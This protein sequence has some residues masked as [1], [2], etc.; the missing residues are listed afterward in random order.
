M[1]FLVLA[2]LWTAWCTLHSLLVSARFIGF[3]K[4]RLGDRYRFTRILF[5]IFAVLSL[6]PVLGYS[7]ALSGD[8]IIHWEGIWR[9]IQIPMLGFSLWLFAAGA[10]AYDLRQ[11]LGIRQIMEHESAMG[12]TR[13]GGIETSGILGRVRHPWYSGAILILWARTIDMATLVTNLVLT[14]YLIT[15]TLLEERKLVSEFGEEYVK[16][17]RT[18]PMLIPRLGV[19]SKA[20]ADD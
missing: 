5:N 13:S 8:P 11:M 14:A 2:I 17:Q 7:H 3:L 6:V 18:V 9:L 15:G 19:G 20:P 10:R 4:D 1:E 16:Y 12:I